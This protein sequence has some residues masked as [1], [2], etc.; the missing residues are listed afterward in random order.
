MKKLSSAENRIFGGILGLLTGDALGVPYEFHRADQI[1]PMELIEMTPP[2]GF[3]RSHSSVLPGTWSDDGAQAMCLLDSLLSCGRFDLK[4][5]S[6]KLLGWYENGLWAIDGKV[7]DVGIQTSMAL[8]QYKLGTPPEQCGFVR[9]D[10][11]GNGALMRVLPLAL[12]HKGSDYELVRD[13]HAQ[14]LITHGNITN[15]VCCALYCLAARELLKGCD[16]KT[17][18]HNSVASIRGLYQDNPD[19][20]NDLEQY[21]APDQPGIWNGKGGGYVV[22]SLRSAF[23]IMLSASSYEEAVKTAVSLGDD[24]DT[25][26]CITGGLAGIMFGYDNIPSRWLDMLKG[27]EKAEFTTAQLARYILGQ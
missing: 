27:R 6:D 7:F 13:A 18:I 24:T 17:A 22:D 8:H 19:H 23:M 25:T 3:I 4:D 5:L 15:Q 10:G 21:I 9:P 12:W 1:P 26:A 20:L 16:M 2:E 11:K 14:C